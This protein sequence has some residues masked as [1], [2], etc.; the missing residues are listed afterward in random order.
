MTQVDAFGRPKLTLPD[1]RH[2]SRLVKSL[3]N[4][5]DVSQVLLPGLTK[6]SSDLNTQQQSRDDG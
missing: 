4:H 5:S 3:Q 1:L 2:Q 6:K